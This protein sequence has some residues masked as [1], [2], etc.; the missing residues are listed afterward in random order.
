MDMAEKHEIYDKVIQKTQQEREEKD[1]EALVS[2]GV[3]TPFSKT[4]GQDFL[5]G[6]LRTL[7]LWFLEEKGF[8]SRY[9]TL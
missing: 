4:L 7:V 9:Q 3:L 5:R 8:D 1:K 2:K 6:F